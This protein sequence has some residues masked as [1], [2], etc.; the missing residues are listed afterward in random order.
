[1]FTRMEHYS[2]DYF[3]L[4]AL[5]LP[6][7]L[8]PT[9]DV[10][11]PNQSHEQF[12]RFPEARFRSCSIIEISPRTIILLYCNYPTLAVGVLYM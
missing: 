7:R 11:Q 6:R 5:M 4:D 3:L 12:H 10:A 8:F 9:H 2:E 1:M